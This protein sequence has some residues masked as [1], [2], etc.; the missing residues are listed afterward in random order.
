MRSTERDGAG[1]EPGSGSQDVPVSVLGRAAALLGAFDETSPVLGTAEL[2]RRTGL[3]KSTVHRL[4]AE[5]CE[6]RLLAREEGGFRLGGWLFELGELVPTHR[7]LSEAAQPIM[8]DL[9]EATHHRVHLAV[10]EGN[11]V[12]YVKILGGAA[13]GLMSRVGG[14]LPAHATGVGKVMLAYSSRATVKA[15]IEGGLTP[16]TA[17]TIT[18]GP[19][20]ILELRRIR[21][22]GMA[23]EVEESHDGVACV[24][25][26]V[27]GADRRITAGLSLT[28]PV[29]KIDPKAL[30]PAVRTAAFVLSRTLRLSGIRDLSLPG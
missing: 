6:W 28:G 23:F 19:E 11:D 12:V 25:A 16:R 15:I 21:S 2:A 8:E 10:L 24:A 17:R 30:G 14:R 1:A 4:A 7:T 26:P 29:D 5:L 20:L 22:I 9:R 3:A 27:F 18:T 13:M